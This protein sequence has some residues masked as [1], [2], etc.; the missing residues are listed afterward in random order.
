MSA[1]IKT[2]LPLLD[3]ESICRALD[4]MGETYKSS[5]NQIIIESRSYYRRCTLTKGNN[6][7]YILA[8][9]SDDLPHSFKNR[10]IIEYKRA[11]NQKLAKIQEEIARQKMLQ[12]QQEEKDYR[13]RLEENKRLELE[14][15]RLEVEHMK[16]NDRRQL[17]EAA[18]AKG[19]VSADTIPGNQA[20]A[21]QKD[22][23]DD[24]IVRL[25]EEKRRLEE[26][27]KLYVENQKQ[28]IY[29]R[30]RKL[31]YSVTETE[32]EGNIKL[33]LVKRTY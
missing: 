26:E 29:D 9:D 28:K 13:R 27:K 12:K 14:R 31:G 25:E 8:G 30:A 16:A 24:A 22:T 20:D 19:T 7:K 17:E 15:K 33:M 23:I 6:G 4:S 21:F 10:L 1:R 18:R 2:V 32:Q 5:E 3:H 11:Y